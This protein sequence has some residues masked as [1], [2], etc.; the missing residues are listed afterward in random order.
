M[1]RPARLLSWKRIW[2]NFFAVNAGRWEFPVIFVNG[3]YR[4]DISRL[5]PRIVFSC[6][7]LRRLF[8]AHLERCGAFPHAE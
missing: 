7:V 2:P 4:R 8:E 5:P 1:V 6:G 3:R